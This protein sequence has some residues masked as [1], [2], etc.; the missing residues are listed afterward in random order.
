MNYRTVFS[1]LFIMLLWKDL[2]KLVDNRTLVYIISWIIYQVY[3]TTPKIV[4]GKNEII[5]LSRVE[6]LVCIIFLCLMFLLKA[7]LNDIS[8]MS[9][10]WRSRHNK[11]KNLLMHFDLNG[12]K[13]KT[14]F[15]GVPLLKFSLIIFVSCAMMSA[16]KEIPKNCLWYLIWWNVTTCISLL[17]K[18]T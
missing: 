13:W 15:Q 14:I 7:S 18:V 4:F 10:L 11:W 6:V 8:D 17:V 12:K 16:W 1:K 9:G 3:M 5:S 2:R